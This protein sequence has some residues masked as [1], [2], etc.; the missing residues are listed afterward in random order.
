L[1]PPLASIACH[2]AA[3]WRPHI[4]GYFHPPKPWTSRPLIHGTMISPFRSVLLTKKIALSAC[5]LANWLKTLA[6]KDRSPRARSPRPSKTG[7]YVDIAHKQV[8]HK[9]HTSSFHSHPS[10]CGRTLTRTLELPSHS[11]RTGC[12]LTAGLQCAPRNPQWSAPPKVCARGVW[13]EQIHTGVEA[14][15][16]Q[17]WNTGG[18]S[19]HD[20]LKVEA[21]GW[22]KRLNLDFASLEEATHGVV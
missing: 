1:A 7:Y 10:F 4:S 21:A 18:P 16:E 13:G 5:L 19:G 12:R 8:W 14:G 20:D 11:H 17:G 22:A 9:C 3:H 2:L 6:Q 15:V